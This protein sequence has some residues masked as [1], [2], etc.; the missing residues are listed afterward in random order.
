VI[1]DVAKKRKA[2]QNN[3]NVV[4]IISISGVVLALIVGI[5]I[6]VYYGLFAKTN[7]SGSTSSMP[8]LPPS[9]AMNQKFSDQPKLYETKYDEEKYIKLARLTD[10]W[11]KKETAIPAGY[12]TLQIPLKYHCALDRQP[13]SSRR[14]CVIE[15]NSDVQLSKATAMMFL[16]TF[17][18]TVEE[19]SP[20]LLALVEGHYSGQRKL[21]SNFR[22]ESPE[23]VKIDNRFA[24]LFPYRGNF[25]SFGK[26][27]E[28]VS[29]CYTIYAL[30]P[31]PFSIL[32]IDIRS[33]VSREEIDRML[34]VVLSL[35][36]GSR[37]MGGN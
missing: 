34:S 5:T 23:F 24:L 28:E 19:P 27:D 21:F 18:P 33:R 36:Y 29:Y 11:Q 1:L 26:S 14:L 20:N 12:L 32:Y 4:A 7:T 37:V 3:A 2:K 10:A 6:L 9:T 17:Q 25:I 8:S 22:Y 16:L 31:D 13:N 30:V 35:K 15:E